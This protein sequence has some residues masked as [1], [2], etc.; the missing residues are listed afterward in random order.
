MSNGDVR[1]AS[2]GSSTDALR[3][4]LLEQEKFVAEILKLRKPKERWWNSS[5]LL[6]GLVAIVSIVVS[7][8]ATIQTQRAAKN[9][10]FAVAQRSELLTERRKLLYELATLAAQVQKAT[11]DRLLFARGVY[12]NLPEP[13]RKSLLDSA[14]AVD[15]RWNVAA[16]SN[17]V[18]LMTLY[19]NG[20]GIPDRWRVARDSL[21]AYV[22][23]VETSYKTHLNSKDTSSTR[24]ADV[25]SRADSTLNQF[26]NVVLAQTT[27]NLD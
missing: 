7:S 8:F 20:T 5:P 25:R 3:D 13:E 11:Q 17:E 2:A 6:T 22:T 24:C 19:G 12:D 16:K 15:D 18:L 4:E 14:N 10:E 26:F 27:T 1:A 21:Q 9:N 23:C